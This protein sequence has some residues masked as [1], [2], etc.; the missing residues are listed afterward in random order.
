LKTR[1]FYEHEYNEKWAE[2]EEEVAESRSR[3]GQFWS[4]NPTGLKVLDVGCGVGSTSQPLTGGNEVYGLELRETAVA[5]A[6]QR[7]V[8]AFVWDVEE[9]FPFADGEFDMVICNQVLEHLFEPR[10]TLREIYRVLKSGGIFLVGVPNHFAIWSRFHILLG[11]DLFRDHPLLRDEMAS[12]HI[13]FFTYK[14]FLKVLKE[15]G[16]ELVEDYS[17]LDCVSPF[18]TVAAAGWWGPMSAWGSGS[19]FYLKVA[20]GL[21]RLSRLLKLTHFIRRLYSPPLFSRGFY[22][23]LRKK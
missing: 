20:T 13:R 16:F 23:K 7:G 8:N 6:I 19:S 14:G 22:L 3:L 10:K 18:K 12:E 15:E 21:N 1:E 9:R 5:K 2:R 4:G 17:I 11:G